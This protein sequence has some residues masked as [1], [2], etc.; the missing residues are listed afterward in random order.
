MIIMDNGFHL[1]ESVNIWK[2]LI[3]NNGWMDGWGEEERLWEEAGKRGE[4]KQASGLSV[5]QL[6]LSDPD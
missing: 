6:R 3:K 5:S 2:R 4:D 1:F